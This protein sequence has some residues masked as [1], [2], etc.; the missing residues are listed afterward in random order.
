MSGQAG[1]Y[2]AEHISTFYD[3]YATKEWDRLVSTP[4]EAVS[5]YIH[6]HYLKRFVKK[7]AR[8]LEAGAGPGRFTIELAKLGAA[9]IVGDISQ[10]QLDL[11]AQHVAEAGFEDRVEARVRLDI[12]DLSQFKN[13]SFDA[14][15]CYGGPVSYVL[16]RGEQAVCE[17]LRVLKPDGYLLLS[18]MSLLGATRAFFEGVMSHE[19]FPEVVDEVNANG[20][21]TSENN[22]G[23]AFKFYRA[24]ELKGVLERAGASVEGLSAS[25]FLSVGHEVLPQ[26]ERWHKVLEWELEYASEP[27]ALDSGTH[28]VAIAKKLRA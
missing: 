14:V 23:H 11:N 16:E 6:T 20:V 10:V 21:L 4:A 15:V 27:G 26:D 8:V 9:I 18:V 24:R 7:G 1:L 25:N 12:T 28:I 5:F 22:K 3:A 19:R 13:H 2:N 17:L